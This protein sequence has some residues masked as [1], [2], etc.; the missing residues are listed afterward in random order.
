MEVTAEQISRAREALPSLWIEKYHIKNEAGIELEFKHHKFLVDI[1]D[2]FSPLQAILKAPQIGMTVCQII[3]SLYVAKKYQKDII[4]TLPTQGDVQDMA[5]GKINRIVAQNPVLME[6][7]K[8]HDTVEQKSVG[9]NIIHY[10]G[11]VDKYTE[12]LTE[13][14]W[15]RYDS[16]NIGDVLP[17][18][19][20][21]TNTV[22]LD[23]VL[24]KTAYEVKE[25]LVRIKTRQID[26]LITKDHRCIVSK[27]TF[28]GNQGKLRVNRAIDLLGKTTANIPVNHN[29]VIDENESNEALFKIVGWV[30]GDGSYWTKRDKSVFVRK[31]GTIN[32]TIYKTKKVCIIQSKFCK[33]LE[34]DL[35]KARISYYKKWNKTVW[36]YQLSSKD[37]ERIIDIIPNKSLNYK[38]VFNCSFK[39]RKALYEGLMM[40]DGNNYS[41]T[42]FYQNRGINVDSFQALMV[43]LGKITSVSDTRNNVTV[44]IK[45]SKVAEVRARL[46]YYEGIVWCPTT[47]NGTIFIRRNGIVSVTGQ[48]FTTKSAMM[49]SSDL[50][51]HDEVD[52]SDPSVIEQYETRLQAKKDGWRWYFSHP[53]SSDMGVDI[54]WKNSDQKHW[55]ITC[56]HCK[57]EQYLSWPDSIDKDKREFVCKECKW[58]LSPEDRENGH[59]KP[60]YSLKWQAE[61]GIKPFSGYWISQMMCSWITADKILKDFE[62]KSPEYFYNYVLGLPYEGGEA[63]LGQQ[64]LFQNLTGQTTAATDDERIIIGVDVG[65]K[66]D[67]VIGNQRLGLFFQD[68]SDN[69]AILDSYLRRWKRAIV[70]MD[71]GGD[72]IRSREFTEKWPG[73]VFLI[74]F[75]AMKE[76]LEIA[77]WG[78]GDKFGSGTVDR[79]RVI[80]WVVD[81]FRNK[82]IPLQGTEN[83]W[84][85]Y[86]VDWNNLNR[87]KIFD[88]KTNVQK[89][90]KWVRNGRD[91]RALATCLWRIGVDK[92]S[93]QTSD[94]IYPKNDFAQRGYEN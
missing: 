41:N 81:E 67:Y 66:I 59:W 17:T 49:V 47:R 62:E 40:S 6:W 13:N 32:P 69:Y 46:E 42:R 1:Y 35:E 72:I 71:G 12:V 78:E 90:Y 43:L 33:E 3:K 21:V 75:T 79:E 50:N 20:I 52:A 30:V 53:S 80:Q 39:E 56:P 68:D 7:I 88:P 29:P 23:T 9:E 77:T 16:L 11:C 60:K 19:N 92:F 74:F 34:A 25:D 91:H 61:N 89:G 28:K 5:G 83:D 51:I 44:S 85:E 48:S 36:V 31:D 58:L 22:E 84:Y 14:G 24:D 63:K 87:I 15:C 70:V 37:G 10:R 26:Q 8:D 38:V 2:D 82:K 93:D 4:Y 55:F 65:N 76:G 64:D 86:W 18:L 54:H 45:T 73:R 57:K 94:I 27:R